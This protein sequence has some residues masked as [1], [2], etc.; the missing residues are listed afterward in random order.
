MSVGVLLLGTCQGRNKPTTIGKRNCIWNCTSKDTCAPNH[1]MSQISSVQATISTRITQNW[2]RSSLSLLWIDCLTRNPIGQC[3]CIDAACF[4]LNSYVN[5]HN[6]VYWAQNNPHVRWFS[7]TKSSKNKHVMG[8]TWNHSF[9]TS[10]SGRRSERRAICVVVEWCVGTTY[11]WNTIRSATSVWVSAR[12]ST[13]SFRRRGEKIIE[14]SSSWAMDW[15]RGTNPMATKIPGP[16]APRFLSSGF[17]WSH[18][19]TILTHAPLMTLKK[20]SVL[21][22]Q[23]SHLRP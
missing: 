14:G 5:W 3:H 21:L 17:I 4:H 12:Y 2:Y 10:I 15:A 22:L 11:E 19:C 23:G 1:A 20:T 8:D 6:A 16:H 7:S 9:G 18:L 13:T